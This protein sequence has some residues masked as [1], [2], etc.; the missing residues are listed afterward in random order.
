[1]SFAGEKG[2]SLT[3]R[4][5][6]II[7]ASALLS[8]VVAAA[9]VAYVSWMVYEGDAEERLVAQLEVVCEQISGLEDEEMLDLLSSINL[10]DARITLVSG[11]GSVV[12]DSLAD[13]GGMENHADREEVLLARGCGEAVVLRRSETTE[14]DSLYA[15]ALVD[16]DGTVLRLA[17]SRISLAVYLESL[18]EPLLPAVLLAAL[19]SVLVARFVTRRTAAPILGINL[20]DPV[21]SGTYRELAPLLDRVAAQRSALM[22]Q[23]EQLARS[24]EMR[25]EFAGNVSHEM[26]SPLQ[27]IGGYAEL[28]ESG[29]AEPDDVRRFAGLIRSE[30]QTMRGLIDDILMLSKLDEGVGEELVPLDVAGIVERVA[31]RLA[32]AAESKGVELKVSSDDEAMAFGKESLV[33]QAVYNLVDNAIRYGGK[34]VR[35][36]AGFE[37]GKVRIAVSDDGPGVPESQRDRV[38][39][40]FYRMDSSRSR[41]TGGTGLGL[42]IVKHAAESMDGAV[43]VDDSTLGGARF[44][45]EL[46]AV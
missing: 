37:C 36:E 41:T 25:R 15:A 33:E 43:F 8:F 18:L 16:G 44:V 11:D 6:A 2:R 26:K 42:A 29:M 34:L 10:A 13:A 31:G 38:F 27:V 32:P 14:A 20:D 5:F 9:I 4:L 40:R 46:R 12:Y 35:V 17:E 19:L 3:A 39:E 1:M 45:L 30:S 7:F 28:I 22:A 24:V 21:Q 23:N